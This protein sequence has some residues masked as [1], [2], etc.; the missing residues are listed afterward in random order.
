MTVI[1]T[2]DPLRA[3]ARNQFTSICQIWIFLLV[4]ISQAG[5]KAFTLSGAPVTALPENLSLAWEVLFAVFDDIHIGR[6][7]A[8]RK[9]LGE[10]PPDLIATLQAWDPAWQVDPEDVVSVVEKAC[11]GGFVCL[12]IRRVV[13]VEA[14]SETEYEFLVEH[15]LED[16]R[17]FRLGPCCGAD[18]TE[19]PPQTHFS[20]RVARDEAGQWRVMWV[21]IYVP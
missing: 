3:P 2:L 8:A 10:L 1:K 17:A 14:I 7:E 11:T 19:M 4:L 12:P 15:A 6:Y 20:Y 18:E 21:P 16:G 5:C 13:A 9:G